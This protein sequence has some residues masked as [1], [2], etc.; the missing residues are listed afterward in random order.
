MAKAEKKKPDEKKKRG[1]YDEKL[2]V[3]GSFM[4]IMKSA[5]KHREKNTAKKK[6]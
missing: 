1:K 4:D 6:D 3:E 2:A 5:V